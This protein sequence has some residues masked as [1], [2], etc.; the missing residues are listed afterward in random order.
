M[1]GSPSRKFF[2]WL[3][4]GATRCETIDMAAL[5]LDIGPGVG[6]HLA[7]VTGG[8]SRETLT[9]ATD[10]QLV[11]LVAAGDHEHAMGALYDRFARR[12]Y[13]L[14]VHQLGARSL[15]DDLVQETFVR[16]WQA[17]PRFDPSKGSAATFIF[18]IAR[19]HAIDLWRRRA[20]RPAEAGEPREES[21]PNGIDRLLVGLALRE[22][23]DELPPPQRE[24]I[25]L[26][27]GLALTQVEI[28]EH[29]GIPLGTVKTRTYHALRALRAGLHE[30]GIDG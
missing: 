2:D 18:T 5:A 7:L 29:L 24:V 16:V 26:A 3:N 23:L 21:M 20:A 4:R 28:A 19:R 22:A 15:A 27:H 17:A 9:Q 6:L 11:A 30:R 8:P 13:G 12:V 25:E 10:E 14:G 1:A